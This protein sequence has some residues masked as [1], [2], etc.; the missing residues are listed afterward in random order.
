MYADILR[1]KRTL[2]WRTCLII[3]ELEEELHISQ[4]YMR[5]YKEI[6]EL[7]S[8]QSD[9]DEY[10]DVLRQRESMG[11]SIGEEL[12]LGELKAEELKLHIRNC[13]QS[14]ES[15]YNKQW[16]MIMKAGYQDSRFAQQ[17]TDYACIYTGKASNLG[18]VS[19]NRP[20]RPAQ[21]FMPHE[22][23]FD[24]PRASGIAGL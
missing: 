7:R 6:E 18:R 21:D 9:L 4:I 23:F 13:T 16:G 20:F 12:I 10:L 5:A 1:S 17:V 19:P 3:P 14:Y 8:L 11:V 24:S 15:N 2:G 22:T